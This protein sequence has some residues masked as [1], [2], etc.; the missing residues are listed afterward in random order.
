MA[1]TIKV[2]DTL[3]FVWDSI[4][5]R[6]FSDPQE[7]EITKIGRDWIYFDNGYRAD[8]RTLIVDGKGY[9]SPGRLW[10]SIEEYH[11]SVAKDRAWDALRTALRDA[12]HRPPHMTEE[13]ILA[14]HAEL[15]PTAKPDAT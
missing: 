8:K 2:G 3:W 12:Y 9:S 5:R 1:D 4:G 14:I 6:R 11:R 15:F 13:R 10:R 7:V